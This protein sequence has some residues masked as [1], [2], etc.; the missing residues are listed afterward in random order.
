M[1][2]E[3]INWDAMAEIA[4]NA[5]HNA[6]APYSKFQVGAALLTKTGEIIGGCNVENAAYPS[7]YC[8]ERGAMSAA[9]VAGHREFSAVLIYTETE[10]LTPPCG[11]CRQVIA[12]FYDPTAPVRAINH[13]GDVKQWT[14]GELIPDAFTPKFLLD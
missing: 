7:A 14:V 9:V 4:K 12:E 10:R 5:A 1:S 3:S 11:G 8:A 2:S 13:L 6:Y